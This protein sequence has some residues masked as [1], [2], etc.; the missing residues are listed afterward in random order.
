MCPYI[1]PINHNYAM[2]SDGLTHCIHLRAYVEV[3]IFCFGTLFPM[4]GS[5]CLLPMKPVAL[6]KCYRIVWLTF[7]WCPS[8]Q[9]PSTPLLV[10]LFS[11]ILTQI[12]SFHTSNEDFNTKSLYTGTKSK[13]LFPLLLTL[14][15]FTLTLSCFFFYSYY[16]DSSTLSVPLSFFSLESKT[17]SC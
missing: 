5:R 4:V 7:R 3:N 10:Y 15:A 17:K 14:R 8:F 11:F 1:S 9:E 13:A 2:Y 12:T 6:H 16:V